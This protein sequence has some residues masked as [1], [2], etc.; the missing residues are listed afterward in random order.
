VFCFDQSTNHNMYTLDALVCS[1]MTL[2][3]KV[4]KKFKFKDGWFICNYEK[5]YS[6]CFSW[7]KKILEEQNMWTGQR[8]D[9]QRKEDDKKDKE[10]NNFAL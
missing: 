5:P 10:T 9:C 2:Y 3:P 1:R 7:M 4:K 6:L 8:L